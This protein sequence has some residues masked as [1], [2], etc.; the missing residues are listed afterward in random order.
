MI[1]SASLAV[2]GLVVV[3]DFDSV[4]FDVLADGTRGA[5][6]VQF[7][8]GGRVRDVLASGADE[9]VGVEGGVSACIRNELAGQ[10]SGT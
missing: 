4:V 7:G 9:A 6:D 2:H 8:V 1:R 10:A 5:S 3:G